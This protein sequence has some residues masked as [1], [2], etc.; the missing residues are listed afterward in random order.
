MNDKKSKGMFDVGAKPDS[1]RTARAKAVLNIDANTPILIGQRKSP[2]GDIVEAAKIAATSGLK[3][4]QTL[5]HTV[6]QY[7]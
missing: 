2:K 6:I 4:H 1:Y 5:Y 3:K 7:L